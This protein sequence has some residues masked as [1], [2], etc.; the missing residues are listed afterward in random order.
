MITTIDGKL[1]SS[2]TDWVDVNL[3]GITIRI[4]V[5]SSTKIGAG[6]IGD[7]I[8]LFTSLQTR[9]DSLTL[10]GFQTVEERSTFEALILVNGI[11]PRLAL[12]ILSN[13]SPD[14]LAIA[15]ASADIESLKQIP[16]VGTRTANRIVLELKGKLDSGLQAVV[17]E[18]K[19][20]DLIEGLSALGY[21]SSEILDAVASLPDKS[22]LSLEEELRFCIQHLGGN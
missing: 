6:N 3:G 19:N 2:G 7:P 21:T 1:A 16:G 15:V 18:P 9:E 17:R 4:S 22:D 13:T 14:T 5:P 10:Y 12:G 20:E 11:G 8:H